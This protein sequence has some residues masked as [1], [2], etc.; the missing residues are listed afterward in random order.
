MATDISKVDN[1]ESSGTQYGGYE[2]EFV[3][4]MDDNL[5]DMFMCKICHLPSRNAQLSV[6]CGHTFCK[7]CLDKIKHSRTCNSKV[8][9]VCRDKKF[10]AVPNKQVDRK[11]RS[12][13]VYCINKK[14]GCEWQGEVNDINGHLSDGCMYESIECTNGCG[15]IL[16]RRCLTQHTITECSHRKI[17]CP[18]CRLSGRHH[19]ITG[20]HMRECPKVIIAC[21]NHCETDNILREDMDEHRKVCSLEVVSC[22]YMKLGCGT[23]MARKEIEK[24]GKEKMEQHLYMATERLEKLENV[25][26]QLVWSFQLASKA[27]S[28]STVNIT[29]VI[30]KITGFA[31]KRSTRDKWWSASFYTANEG[32]EM[33]AEVTFANSCLKVY[34]GL[35]DNDEDDNLTWP[36]R[37]R[38]DVAIL[39]QINDDKHYLRRVIFDDRCADDVAGRAAINSW[40][41]T[42]FITY[43]LLC[44]TSATRQYVKDD[45][46]YIKVSYHGA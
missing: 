24:H 25:V 41:Y 15:E 13:R 19:F 5:E 31:D 33:Y 3:Q 4:G 36:F 2:F 20:D 11:I 37:G 46:M 45:I 29:P 27:A 26:T 14:N 22:K 35:G 6:C 12:L 30:F 40:G 28:D 9:P 17:N 34:I 10:G 38:F 43:A 8:C 21:P 1:G 16:Q 42:E 7:S 44:R 23:R 39:N 32:Y 18:H